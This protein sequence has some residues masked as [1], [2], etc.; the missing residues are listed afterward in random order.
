MVEG[1]EELLV[2]GDVESVGGGGGVCVDVFE[3][4]GVLEVVGGVKGVW[5]GVVV[6]CEGK[7]V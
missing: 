4:E 6:G 3:P 2:G 5:G 1:G 7:K